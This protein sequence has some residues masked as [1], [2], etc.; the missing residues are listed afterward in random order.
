MDRRALIELGRQRTRVLLATEERTNNS[1][2][3]NRR[4]GE[5]NLYG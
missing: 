3:E 2:L 5:L 1:D 4:D